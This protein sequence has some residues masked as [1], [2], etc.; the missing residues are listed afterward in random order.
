[1]NF[2]FCPHYLSRGLQF[3]LCFTVGSMLQAAPWKAGSIGVDHIKTYLR[4]KG[5]IEEVTLGGKNHLWTFDMAGRGEAVIANG[6]VLGATRE[7]G[8]T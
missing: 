1:M 5:L 6:R 2:R 7:A 4:R 8:R 3:A